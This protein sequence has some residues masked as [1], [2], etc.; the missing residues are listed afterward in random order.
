MAREI[1][2]AEFIASLPPLPDEVV[3]RMLDNA[4]RTAR[5]LSGRRG[6]R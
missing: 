3:V 2:P 5:I 6:T 4:E 1:T